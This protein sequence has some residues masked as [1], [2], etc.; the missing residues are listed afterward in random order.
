MRRRNRSDEVVASTGE[1]LIND[2]EYDFRRDSATDDT[3]ARTAITWL[4]ESNLLT[5]EENRVQ[6][7]PSSLRVSSVE[8]A[9]KKLETR[10]LGDPARE[11]LLAIVQKLL[12]ANPDEGISTDMLMAAVG[13]SPGQVRGA[14]YD[15]EKC[16]I[17]SNDT[18]LTA[19]VHAGVA[20]NSRQR[21]TEAAGVEEKLLELMQEMA[22]DMAVGDRAPLNLKD[23]YL[24]FAGRKPPHHRVHRAI[25]SL[26]PNDQLQVR[27]RS[28]RWELLDRA[29]VV[30]GT[31][32]RSYGLPEG[33]ACTGATVLAIASWSRKHSEPQYQEQLRRET[34]EVV[35]PELVFEP[36]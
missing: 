34:W 9:K 31:L 19:F 22:P 12:E 15:L 11:R 20:R 6:I 14:L 25:A 8:E 29:E 35:I 23:V 17:A 5:R 30:V 36:S 27:M 32:S 1:I 33:M 10:R 28:G 13:L 4:E 21:L 26:S 7:F 2:Q 24:S 3:R 16:G 18:V